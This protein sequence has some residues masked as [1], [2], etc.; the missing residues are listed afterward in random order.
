MTSNLYLFSPDLAK[1]I[2]DHTATIEIVLS[3]PSVCG[4]FKMNCEALTNFFCLNAKQLLLYA[5]SKTRT[6]LSDS[7]FNIITAGHIVLL[8]EIASNDLINEA[9]I[10]VLSEDSPD[11]PSD[12]QLSRIS[13]VISTIFTVDLSNF[14]VYFPNKEIEIKK[15]HSKIKEPKRKFKFFSKFKTKKSQKAKFEKLQH[16]KYF[17]FEFLYILLKYTEN[18]NI[19]FLFR[20]LFGRNE[21]LASIQNIISSMKFTQNISSSLFYMDCAP[22]ICNEWGDYEE[23]EV[24]N[25]ILGSQSLD[26]SNFIIDINENKSKEEIATLSTNQNLIINVSN[27]FNNEDEGNAEKNKDNYIEN[28]EDIV[29]TKEENNDGK[30]KNIN[31]DFI[32]NIYCI[33]KT[34]NNDNEKTINEDNKD[35]NNMPKKHFNDNCDHENIINISEKNYQNDDIPNNT[36]ENK[37]ISNNNIETGNNSNE[38]IENKLNIIIDIGNDH[39]NCENL[40][41]GN[42]NKSNK[43]PDIIKHNGKFNDSDFNTHSNLNLIKSN[44]NTTNNIQLDNNSS[45]FSILSYHEEDLLNPIYL[46]MESL[47]KILNTAALNPIF[48]PEFLELDVYSCLLQRLHVPYFVI[49]AQWQTIQNIVPTMPFSISKYFIEPASSMFHSTPARIHMY[50]CYSLK[51]LTILMN[52][53]TKFINQ[54]FL[55]TILATFIKFDTC[56]MLHESIR[57]FVFAS[58][59]IPKINIEVAL[60][61]VPVLIVECEL[62]QYGIVASS[63]FPILNAVYNTSLKSKNLAVALTDIDGFDLFTQ[64]YLKRY[65]KLISYDYGGPKAQQSQFVLNPKSLCV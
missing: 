27:S 35:Y 31:N 54:T 62:R 32:D 48:Q 60:T 25:H 21:R 5:F 18:V 17:S 22:N 61:F 13:D 52:N 57:H 55:N 58:M 37:K 47:Y 23:S 44:D 24:N 38:N 40:N 43:K 15:I 50:H 56:T 46:K 19:A 30:D 10:E 63:A 2:D 59:M 29:M 4:I 36:D 16:K 11:G 49:N 34:K 12:F 1:C 65:Q 6:H 14:Q 8:Q 20:M 45:T 26:S 7:A 51:I 33:N 64:K 42:T 3:E 53:S 39:Y 9:I 41:T 28:T